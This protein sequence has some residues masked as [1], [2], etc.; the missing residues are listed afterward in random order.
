MTRALAGTVFTTVMLCCSVGAVPAF[1]MFFRT[2]SATATPYASSTLQPP[3]T[4]SATC[5]NAGPTAT[6]TINWTASA[7]AYTTGYSITSTPAS[8]TKTTAA[9]GRTTTIT[10]LTKGTN[11]SFRVV[12]TYLNWTSTARVTASVAC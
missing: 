4:A 11:Y 1:A 6:A 9:A 2:V 10:G 8:S 12:A 7:S 5:A 3:A